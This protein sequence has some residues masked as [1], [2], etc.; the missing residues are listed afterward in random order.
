MFSP[1]PA[2][3]EDQHCRHFNLPHINGQTRSEHGD[4]TLFAVISTC[5]GYMFEIAEG[6]VYVCVHVL[7]SGKQSVHLHMMYI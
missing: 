5:L 7:G 2:V 1:L 3:K 6:H 4:D